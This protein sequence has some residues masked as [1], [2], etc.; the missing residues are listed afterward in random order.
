MHT[1]ALLSRMIAK[2][3]EVVEVNV[4]ILRDGSRKVRAEPANSQ[5]STIDKLAVIEERANHQFKSLTN[6]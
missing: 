3:S 6:N 2:S 5:T 1:K 4:E